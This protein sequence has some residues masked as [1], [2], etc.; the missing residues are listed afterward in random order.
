[1]H[2]DTAKNYPIPSVRRLP[3]YLRLLR[4]LN[5]QGRESVSC[6]HIAEHLGLGTVQVRKD[7]AMTGIIGRPKVGYPVPDLIDAIE[8]FLG[9]KTATGALL[10]GVG[11]LGSAILGYDGFKSHGL[12][13]VAAFDADPRKIG[14]R[15]HGREVLPIDRLAQRAAETGARIGIVTVPATAAQDATERLILAGVRAIWNFSPATLEVPPRIIVE[16][17]RF[18]DSLAVLSQRLHQLGDGGREAGGA[19]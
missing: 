17:V 9:W 8:S 14:Q 18:V 3:L 19:G 5:S 12:D 2:A 4:Q 1:M 13:I 10:V 6:T 7:L 15:V 16:N 11:S